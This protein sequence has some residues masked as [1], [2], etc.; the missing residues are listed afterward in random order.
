MGLFNRDRRRSTA[1]LHREWAEA[2]SEAHEILQIVAN[3]RLLID[4]N[5][6]C[7]LLL[8]P[9]E[10]ALLVLHGGSLVETR[11]SPVS[12]RG[13]GLG[14]SFSIG[15]GARLGMHNFESIPSGGEEQQTV[16]D[17]GVFVVTDR[18]GVFSGALQVREF[19]WEKLLSVQLGVLTRKSLAM[20]LPVSNRQKVSGIAGDWDTMLDIPLYVQLG[21]GL[22][23][24]GE[25][26][27]MTRLRGELAALYASEPPVAP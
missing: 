15:G 3:W 18:R 17:R 6:D 13:G 9:G 16:I 23:R 25:N 14:S 27:L 20:Y 12:Y 8:H 11:R 2:V 1:N 10:H 4:E 7:P 22:A 24:E 19:P 21:V 26:G 5:R